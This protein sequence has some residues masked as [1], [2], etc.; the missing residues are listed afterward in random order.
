MVGRIVAA[1]TTLPILN[2]LLI[3]TENGSLQ[4]SST[5]LE[6]AITTQIRCKIEN[7]GQMTVTSKTFGELVSNLPNKNI[8]IESVNGQV[9]VVA[10]NYQTTIKTLPAEE[11]PLIPEIESREKISLDAQA[12][13]SAIDQVV[14][15]VSTNQTQPEIT[16][17]LFGFEAGLLRL[18][19]TDRYRLAEKKL[20]LTNHSG[21]QQEIIVPHKTVLELSRIIG[22][23]KGVVE[24]MI[25]ET[26]VA[27]GFNET[28]I[29]SRLVDGQYPD[30]KQIIPAEFSTRIVLDRQALVG[31]LKTSSIFSQGTNS[32]KLE[33][34]PAD[35]KLVLVTE[36]QELGKSVVN[37]ESKVEGVKGV[38]ILNHRYVLDCLAGVSAENVIIKILND[39]SPS[40]IVPEDDETYLYLVMPIKS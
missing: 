38:V 36:S 22:P 7:E 20:S 26:Q 18:V 34:D 29:I 4:I 11:F 28:R 40:L 14:F 1:N 19:A 23:Q 15:A 25:S 27:F 8:V 12:L 37:L 31:A 2:N 17:V 16:G 32:V 9:S 39:S 33:Y 3:K 30:Y 35:Q 21:G 13:K 5:N 6:I 24:I 10:E